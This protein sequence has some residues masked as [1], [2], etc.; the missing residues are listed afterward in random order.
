MMLNL[1][2]FSLES[3][4]IFQEIVIVFLLIS[5]YYIV[6][7]TKSCTVIGYSSRQ[8]F[9]AGYLA[10]FGLQENGALCAIYM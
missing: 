7:W 5:S 1:I 3:L 10:C 8:D 6:E 4:M 2:E 9:L